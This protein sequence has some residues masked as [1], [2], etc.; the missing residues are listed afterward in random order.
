MDIGPT[1]H[2]MQDIHKKQIESGAVKELIP[3]PVDS[4]IEF[5][6]KDYLQLDNTSKTEIPRRRILWFLHGLYLMKVNEI[7]EHERSYESQLAAIW[8]HLI[9]C[10]RVFKNALEH[11]V[12]WSDEEKEWFGVTG[13]SLCFVST[14]TDAMKFCKNMI[15]PHWFRKNDKLMHGLAHNCIAKMGKTEAAIYYRESATH[16]QALAADKSESE[17]VATMYG[18]IARKHEEIADDLDASAAEI[19]HP[20]VIWEDWLANRR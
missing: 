6:W 19:R 3:N 17:I 5:L 1:L 13:K 18:R 20:A 2:A 14:E 9:E 15:V 4:F 8:V 11:N 16:L 7:A 10:S 12:I